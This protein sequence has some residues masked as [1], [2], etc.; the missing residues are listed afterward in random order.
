MSE[1]WEIEAGSFLPHRPTESLAQAVGDHGGRRT[2]RSWGGRRPPSPHT[3]SPEPRVPAREP[4]E[5]SSVRKL[6]PFL[7]GPA[8]LL[9]DQRHLSFDDEHKAHLLLRE[10]LPDAPSVPLPQRDGYRVCVLLVQ[11]PPVPPQPQGQCPGPSTAPGN[12]HSSFH[13]SSPE[14]G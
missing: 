8:P 10:V 9:H 7:Q 11:T 13:V 4:P 14:A 12:D 1:A 5:S 2:G 6:H 3:E